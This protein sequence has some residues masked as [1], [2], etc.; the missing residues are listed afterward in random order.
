MVH[1]HILDAKIENFEDF[2]EVYG[3]VAGTEVQRFTSL[4]IGEIVDQHGTPND[5]LGHPGSNN[6]VVITYTEKSDTFQRQLGP[7]VLMKKCNNIT[8]S[9]TVNADI[10]CVTTVKCH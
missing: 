7:S 5:F 10:C 1:G 3:F 4:I 6:F 2:K 8:P 9:L